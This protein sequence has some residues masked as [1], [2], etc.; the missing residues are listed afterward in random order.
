MTGPDWA[1]QGQFNAY[2][3]E[4]V[5]NVRTWFGSAS[6]IVETIGYNGGSFL[7]V[8]SK[9]YTTAGNNSV[10]TSARLPLETCILCKFTTTQRT[11]K[12]HPIYLFKYIHAVHSNSNSTPEVPLSGQ[13]SSIAGSLTEFLAGINDGTNLRKTCGPRG[14]VAQAAIIETYVSHRDFRR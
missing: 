12:N 2:S 3:D 11:S 14:A 13:V 9:V 1:S 4:L 6:T 8:F 5:A 10:G 7:P